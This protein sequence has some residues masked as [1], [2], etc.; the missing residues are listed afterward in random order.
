M[1]RKSNLHPDWRCIGC[2]PWTL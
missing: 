2:R 1:L